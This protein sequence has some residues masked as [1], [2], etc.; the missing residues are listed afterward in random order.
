[1]EFQTIYLSRRSCHYIVPDDLA[2]HALVREAA[3]GKVH[4]R[5]ARDRDITLDIPLSDK[6]LSDLI[7]VLGHMYG[8]P[9]AKIPEE[10]EDFR[11]KGGPVMDE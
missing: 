7:H 9:P 2:F 5:F 4:I 10:I 3:T 8:T 1:M 6:N 11:L